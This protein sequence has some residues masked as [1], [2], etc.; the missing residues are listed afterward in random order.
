MTTL[1]L[2]AA[3]LL[4]VVTACF[5]VRQRH[6]ARLEAADASNRLAAEVRQVDFLLGSRDAPPGQIEEGMALCRR[7]LGHYRVLDDPAWTARPAVALLP[8][9]ER[10]RLRREIGHLLLLDARALIWQAESTDRPRAAVRAPRAGHPPEWQG[11]G[12]HGR[13]RAV[14]RPVAPA[15][16]PGPP[17]RAGGR[18]RPAPASRPKPSRHRRP[19]IATG[20]SSTGSTIEAARAIPRPPGS[21]RRSWPRS[22]TSRGA[23]YRTS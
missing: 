19:S 6:L 18:G 10:D 17:R 7:I 9:D 14:P 3:G 1:V 22:R 16:R 21:G 23:T 15:I 8:P 2:V 11:R 12:C 5:L 20:T 13:S 4:A